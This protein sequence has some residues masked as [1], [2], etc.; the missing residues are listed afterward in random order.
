MIYKYYW[1]IL[2]SVVFEIGLAQ[3]P[4]LEIPSLDTVP[5]VEDTFC[6]NGNY[7]YLC[8]RDGKHVGGNP[9]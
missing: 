8:K 2:A 6:Q 1:A 7:C 3:K 9:L 4:I 5:P